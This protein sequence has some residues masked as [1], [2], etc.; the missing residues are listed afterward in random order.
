MLVLV[1]SSFAFAALDDAE[2]YYSFDNDDNT[3]SNPDDIS[4]NANDGTNNGATTGVTGI[5]NEA[6]DYDGINDRLDTGY[7]N[8][9][10]ESYSFHFW[11]DADDVTGNAALIGSLDTGASNR[12]ELF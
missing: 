3:G 8:S 9:A 2:I 4:G 12:I 6:Y 1:M 7:T 10:L 11:I 5:I